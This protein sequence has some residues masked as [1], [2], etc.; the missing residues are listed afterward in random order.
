MPKQLP[1][2][3]QDNSKSVKGRLGKS[4]TAAQD[5]WADE[6]PAPQAGIKRTEA[7]FT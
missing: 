5:R 4:S 2:L 7:P 6:L 1:Q 3:L